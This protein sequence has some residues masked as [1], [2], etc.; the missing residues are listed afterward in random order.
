MII[1]NY[2][3]N[4]N[5][6]HNEG[7]WV[8]HQVKHPTLDL[9]SGHDLMV[10]E[11][12]PGAHLCTDSGEPAWDSFFPLSLSIYAPRHAYAHMRTLALYLSK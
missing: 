10:R 8:A 3:G 7:A 11:I 4:A 1:A 2:Q 6:N 9:G 5:Q 12:Q